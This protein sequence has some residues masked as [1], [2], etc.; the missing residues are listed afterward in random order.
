MNL[1]QIFFIISGLI[2]LLFALDIA[3]KKKFNALHFLVFIFIGFGLLIFTFFPEILNKFW[4]FF[5]LQRWADVLVYS[6]IIFLVYFSLLLLRKVENNGDEFT[7]LIREMAINFSNK[8][9]VEWKELFI[10]PSYNEA[11]V[12]VNTIEDV[13]GAWYQNILVVNDGSHDRTTSLLEENF[14]D[15]IIV[16]NHFKNRGQ[17]ASL[18]TGFEYARRYSNTDYVITFDADGQHDINDVKVFEK[19]LSHHKWVDIL[20]GSRFMWKK[21]TGVPF[22]RRIILKLGILFT[23]FLSNI[24][25]SDTHN[26]FRVIKTRSLNKIKLTIDGMWHASE[27]LD[28]IASEKL[29]FKEVPVTIK[30]TDYSIKKWQSSG[31]AI[32]IAMR[33]IW[34]KFFK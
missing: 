14:W 16:L 3:K 7:E 9:I 31:N 12:I 27:I 20:L 4:N 17:W 1:L 26:G 23:Y 21:Q 19:Y 5:W 2:I 8:K 33:M 29:K 22:T 11:S 13:L 28:I 32:K 25:L 34:N 6:G 10:I 18:E 24:Q 15:S 30:Y